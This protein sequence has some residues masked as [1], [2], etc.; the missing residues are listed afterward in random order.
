M[1]S[2]IELLVQL[3]VQFIVNVIAEAL[4]EAAF[5]GAAKALRSQVGRA[6]V[7]ALAGF[8]VGRGGVRD[9]GGL[10]PS[11]PIIGRHESPGSI[12]CEVEQTR[13]R[14]EIKQ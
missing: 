7:S 6:G 2:I 5:H 1:D 9:R 14:T 3:V 11:E 13:S 12:V 4:V 10:F 8:G